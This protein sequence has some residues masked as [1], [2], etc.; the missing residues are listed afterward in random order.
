[1][2]Y[3]P[4]PSGPIGCVLNRCTRLSPETT[5]IL[6]LHNS[7]QKD[8]WKH[9]HDRMPSRRAE[10]SVEDSPLQFRDLWGLTPGSEGPPLWTQLT[11]L[12]GF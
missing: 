2:R 9:C 12:H 4:R 7:I 5:V 3:K 11:A 1:M 10:S 8:K 6:T